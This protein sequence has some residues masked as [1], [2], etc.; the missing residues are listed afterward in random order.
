M[1]GLPIE[2]TNDQEQEAVPVRPAG[3]TGAGRRKKGDKVPR[4][5]GRV[6]PASVEETTET[7]AKP[8]SAAIRRAPQIVA[9]LIP[10]EDESLTVARRHLRRCESLRIVL[11]ALVDA[12]GD[13]VAFVLQGIVEER[14]REI[15]K[16]RI[17]SLRRTCEIP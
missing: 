14:R 17:E 15:D 1:P 7:R 16:S 13:D 11:Q 5:S 4:V 9:S 6:A 2:V 12:C 3:D 10:P 8:R